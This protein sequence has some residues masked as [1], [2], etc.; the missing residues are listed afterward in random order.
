M[1]NIIRYI[2]L[3]ITGIFLSLTLLSGISNAATG[4][5]T[6]KIGHITYAKG[7]VLVR[8]KGTWMHLKKTPWPLYATDRVVTKSGRA[9]INLVDGGMVRMN[10]DTSLRIIRTKASNGFLRTK[11]SKTTEV[12]VLT[13]N[14]WF[15]VKLKK[16]KSMRFRTPS[17]IAEIRGTE[18]D[19]SVDHQGKTNFHLTEG[20][21]KNS[22]AFTQM[23]FQ[24]DTK[25]GT[26]L[27]PSSDRFLNSRQMKAVETA[28]KQSETADVAA[29]KSLALTKSADELTQ[30][31]K[32]Q[33]QVVR[34]AKATIKAALSQADAAESSARASVLSMAEE[35]ESAETLKDFKNL[36]AAQDS[37]QN[38]RKGLNKVVEQNTEAHSMAESASYA[39]SANLTTALSA[40]VST[41]A[42]SAIAHNASVTA[43]K[44]AVLAHSAGDTEAAKVAQAQARAARESARR[45]DTVRHEVS[46]ILQAAADAGG[47]GR[48]AAI[49]IAAKVAAEAASVHAANAEAHANVATEAAAG[50]DVSMAVAVQAAAISEKISAQ[51]VSVTSS[52]SDTMLSGNMDALNNALK[53]MQKISDIAN[54]LSG[55]GETPETLPDTPEDIIITPEETDEGASETENGQG[56]NEDEQSDPVEDTPP[57]FNPG[58]PSG[59]TGDQNVSPYTF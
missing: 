7:A 27:P 54:D 29:S 40:M 30:K 10:I 5:G 2:S 25:F 4:N 53:A 21:T 44:Q 43:D 13:G 17:M 42:G 52:L 16:N 28:V 20:R 15:Q 50:D 46:G 58:D 45:V 18:G 24:S 14:V 31:A 59:G 34:A 57:P 56:N 26:T 38:A 9:S 1:Q 19:F 49:S 23:E 41:M 3:A 35:V 37:L 48:A 39:S 32:T 8:S 22:G 11:K 47:N 12:N 6:M 36:S 33:T 55:N 51:A